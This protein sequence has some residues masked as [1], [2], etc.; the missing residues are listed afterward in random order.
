[1]ILHCLASFEAFF[2]EHFSYVPKRCDLLNQTDYDELIQDNNSFFNQ[3]IGV[4]VSN[5]KWIDPTAFCEWVV[6]VRNIRSKRMFM[7][8]V[9]V[10]NFIFAWDDLPD[11]VLERYLEE[12]L[13]HG[14]RLVLKYYEP[15]Y[16]EVV[17][18]ECNY[19]ILRE[20]KL[21][22]TEIKK[23]LF[24]SNLG[25]YWQARG[26]DAGIHITFAA[27]AP[28]YQNEDLM[29][30]IDSGIAYQLTTKGIAFINDV[31]SYNKEKLRKEVGTANSLHFTDVK[32]KGKFIPFLKAHLKEIEE[33]V[34]AI[35]AL[36]EPAQ[37]I[38]LDALYGQFLWSKDAP[39]YTVG[40]IDPKL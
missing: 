12:A 18:R 24:G 32:D 16:Q 9:A 3:V 37:S 1:L 19:F 33:D 28:A 35:K 10:L 40:W 4:T 6:S 38:L 7:G 17:V 34:R 27:M 23:R 22:R 36:P 13:K 2:S 29:F 20:C 5:E 39:R 8:F 21:R 26:W 15:Q 25:M 31:F 11:E 30:W 14:K